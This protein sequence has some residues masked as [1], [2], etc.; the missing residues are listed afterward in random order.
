MVG[1]SVFGDGNAGRMGWAVEMVRGQSVGMA[2]Q[3][4]AMV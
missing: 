2:A 1:L 3:R 4:H